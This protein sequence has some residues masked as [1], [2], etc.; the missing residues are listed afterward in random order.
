MA[1]TD[2]C[3]I[4][5]GY[6]LTE[7]SPVVTVNPIDGIQ[8]GTIGLPL[9]DTEVVVLSDDGQVMPTGAVGELAVKGPQV[10]RGYWN[11]PEATA[12]VMS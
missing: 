10:M 2:G 11:R 3:A 6:G 1:A 9:A 5:E 4:C 7:T 8:L 12:E